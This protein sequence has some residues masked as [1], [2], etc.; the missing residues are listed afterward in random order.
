MKSAFYELVD[1]LME[2]DGLSLQDAIFAVND[3]LRRVREGDDPE[4]VL[5]EDFGLELDYIFAL[6]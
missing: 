1:V 3:A 4:E 2:R 6:I 5:Y